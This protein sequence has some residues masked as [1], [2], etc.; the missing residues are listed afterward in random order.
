MTRPPTM[1]RR[2]DVTGGMIHLLAEIGALAALLA[3]MSVL[4]WVML[5]V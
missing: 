5:L 2:S 4:A 1:R 3:V